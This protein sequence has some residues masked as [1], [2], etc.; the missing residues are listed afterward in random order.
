MFIFAGTAD[1]NFIGA[2]QGLPAITIQ[3]DG[4]VVPQTEYIKQEGSIYKLTA[5]LQQT[6]VIVINCSNIVFDGQGHVINGTE[7]DETVRKLGAIGYYSTGITLEGVRNVIVK[8]VA[9]VGFTKYETVY[10][11]NCSKVSIIGLNASLVATED[12]DHNTLS[13]N[14]ISLIF[15]NSRYNT[16]LKNNVTLGLDK[17]STDN[18]FFENNILGVDYVRYGGEAGCPLAAWDNGS[19]GNYW[20]DYMDRYPDALEIGD[21]G[22]ADKPYVVDGDNIDHYPL[23]HP[24]S[25]QHNQEPSVYAPNENATFPVALV[26]AVI[27]MVTAGVTVG[28]LYYQKRHRRQ[29]QITQ[30]LSEASKI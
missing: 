1:A 21:T 9:I 11:N 7:P 23:M 20:S 13:N 29:T 28:L 26:A 16:I 8:D 17:F 3:N 25:I 14:V 24:V 4:S 18:L 15:R 6:Y 27:A 19:V 5:D 2:L 12:S 10:L 22:I 30:Q